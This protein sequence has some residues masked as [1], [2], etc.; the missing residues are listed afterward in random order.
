MNLSS[1]RGPANRLLAA[2]PP[3]DLAQLLSG[4]EE[5]RLASGQILLGPGEPLQQVYFPLDGVLALSVLME[6]GSAIEVASVGNEGFVDVIS[7][8]N[9][10]ASSYEVSCQIDCRALRLEVEHLRRAFRRSRAVRTLLLRYAGVMLGTT[11]RSV[12][13]SLVHTPSQRLARWLLMTADRV[14]AEL[15]LTH[16][17]LASML[18]VRR[19][20]VSVIAKDFRRRGLIEYRRGRINIIDRAGLE[21]TACEDYGSFQREYGRLLGPVLSGR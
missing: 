5:V 21:A 10:D 19:A 17:Q 3:A 8:L 12:A 4:L 13:C 9:G 16:E 1:Q 18:G 11:G 7:V 2:L 20:T 14:A 15:P 6:D